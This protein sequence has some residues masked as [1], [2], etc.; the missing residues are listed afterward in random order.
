MSAVHP[1]TISTL[2]GPGP[3]VRRRGVAAAAMR[4]VRAQLGTVFVVA[5]IV[6]GLTLAVWSLWPDVPRAV[7]VGGREPQPTPSTGNGVARGGA[8]P[9]FDERLADLRAAALAAEAVLADQ[10]RSNDL[11]DVAPADR[12][13]PK[14]LSALVDRAG[15]LRSRLEEARLRWEALR[16][17][18]IDETVDLTLFQSDRL[19]ELLL[20][21][22]EEKRKTAAEPSG[23]R[24][25]AQEAAR[26]RIAAI[27]DSIRRE[28][29]RIVDE[30]RAE[31]DRLTEKTAAYDREIAER[32]RERQALDRKEVALQ[33]LVDRA[34]ADRRAYEQALAGRPAPQVQGT[35]ASAEPVA[36]PAASVAPRSARPG[37]VPVGLAG[38][39]AG[40]C[41]GVLW[42]L[43]GRRPE[44]RP[45]RPVT[46]GSA[47][48]IGGIRTDVPPR[49]R[50]SALLAAHH[51]PLV[52]DLS[53]VSDD[54]GHAEL[55]PFVETLDAHLDHVPD[56]VLTIVGDGGPPFRFAETLAEVAEAEGIPTAFR[57][58]G[59]SA[60]ADAD[61]EL[62]LELDP[63]DHPPALG[64]A[65]FA[66]LVVEASEAGAGRLA[67]R[68][69]TWSADAERIVA[70]AVVPP[71]RG[72]A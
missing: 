65:R 23:A 70:V 54:A 67:A 39:L 68:L 40:L 28:C 20:R 69:A 26:S 58:S 24:R 19:T 5:G 71:R 12:A 53:R 51:V 27:E 36:A 47:P 57:F 22:W 31:V 55:E 18:K 25:A 17:E 62:V 43:I 63:G 14:R 44:P 61:A 34:A 1:E 16:R 13:D 59:R 7:G 32:S 38:L 48:L 33:A 64:A 41:A 66:L 60:A 42:V 49:E 29:A 8:S 10:R 15:P 50:I 45:E 6:L 37:I 30:A 21:L 35:P 3:D 2:S 52:A 72:P 4:R 11:A 46:E 56:I 9:S